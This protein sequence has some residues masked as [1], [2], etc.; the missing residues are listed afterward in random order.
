MWTA[1]LVLTLCITSATAP[2]ATGRSKQSTKPPSHARAAEIPTLE[3]LQRGVGIGDPTDNFEPVIRMKN[4][5]IKEESREQLEQYRIHHIPESN[6]HLDSN[7]E[8]IR[9]QMAYRRLVQALIV[10]DEKAK[11]KYQKDAAKFMRETG[12]SLKHA[13]NEARKEKNNKGHRHKR[14]L[15]DMTNRYWDKCI[16][17]YEYGEG[18]TGYRYV[19]GPMQT[20]EYYTGF[21]FVKWN[22][23]VQSLYGLTHNNRLRYIYENGCWSFVG[24]L[25]GS[26]QSI[27]CCG[28][29]TCMHEIGHALGFV[30]EQQSPL[31][32]DYLRVEW[33]GINPSYKGQYNR[34]NRE[35]KVLFGYYDPT[36][37]MHYGNG[38]FGVN[39]KPTMYTLDP[40]RDFL[41]GRD[42]TRY[43]YFFKEAMETHKCFDL[44]CNESLTC[45][46]GGYPSVVKGECLCV[47][48]YGLDPKTRCSSTEKTDTSLENI[49]WPAG[50]FTTL[51]TVDGCPEGFKLGWQYH[52]PPNYIWGPSLYNA[53]PY[54]YWWHLEHEFCS[55]IDE[56]ND[57][58]D[59]PAG[60]YCIYRKGGSCPTGFE[61]G[62]IQMDD[63]PTSRVNTTEGE[64]PDGVYGNN[65][66]WE[67]C[68]RRDGF[69]KTPIKLPTKHPF[70]LFMKSSC[71]VVEG[72]QANMEYFNWRSD[73][74]DGNNKFGGSLPYYFKFTESQFNLYFCYYSKVFKDCGGIYKLNSSHATNPLNIQ[75][76][77]YPN[78]Y[79]ENVD[80]SYTILAPENTTIQL[81]FNDFEIKCKRDTV[82]VA[83]SMPGHFGRKYCGSG[84][85][86]TVLSSKNYMRLTLLSKTGGGSSKGFSA[87]VRV[88]YDKCFT[89]N[90]KDRS[91]SGDMSYTQN[92]EPC[93]PWNEVQNCRFH[94]FAPETFDDD[95]SE[96]FCRNTVLG[97][98][99]WC[100][101]NA[102]TCER[103]YCDA[104]SKR[105]CYDLFNDCAALIA[106]NSSFCSINLD[107]Q[108]LR[109]CR[110][111]CGGC[112][113]VDTDKT[114][115][116]P[117]IVDN[118]VPSPAKNSSSVGD[119]VKYVCPTPG[120]NDVRTRTCTSSGTWT[121]LGF[122][123]GACPEG[124]GMVNGRCYKW[125]DTFLTHD[126][127][128]TF[129]EGL[130]AGLAVITSQK[131]HDYVYRIVRFDVEAMEG[132]WIALKRN[133]NTGQYEWDDGKTITFS[134][135]KSGE[136]DCNSDCGIYDKGGWF[137][138]VCDYRKTFVCMHTPS[139]RTTCADQSSHC[140]AFI[141]ATPDLCVL[142]T[143]FAYANCPY[144]CGLCKTEQTTS[145]STSNSTSTS[146][147]CSDPGVP[148]NTQ[149]LSS[150]GDITVGQIYKYQCNNGTALSSGD[151]IRACLITGQLTGSAPS[152]DPD[153]TVE[154]PV[155]NISIRRR[156]EHGSSGYVYTTTNQ[157]FKITKSGKLTKWRFYSSH[158]GSI[159]L[160]VWRFASGVTSSGH[161]IGEN[162]VNRT[163]DD[164]V[165]TIEIPEAQQI[166]V[167]DGD[168]IAVHYPGSSAAGIPFTRCSLD[169]EPSKNN[170]L[171]GPEIEPSSLVEGKNY[172][173]SADGYDCKTWSLNAF[174][175]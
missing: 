119:Q 30:H 61:S 22:E 9:G 32:D 77:N 25:R 8:V 152:C 110:R 129:C 127:A 141:R 174:I 45:E 134:G 99:P 148:A 147:L 137:S 71:Q 48:P 81:D 105:N 145:K 167:Q 95:L 170:Q 51:N 49:P 12:L 173:F 101:T 2:S 52:V 29:S 34:V 93:L 138:T 35:S 1:T 86:K 171:K 24:N 20:F 114:C 43:Y 5:K 65:T 164:R 107:G 175:K 153:S 76:L 91:Y 50:S 92:F 113:T 102:E 15:T 4:G 13:E 135:W 132:V 122:V 162:T 59:W 82:E 68:C 131:Q 112:K 11:T 88:I 160:Q 54:W 75:S 6:G 84:F 74:A 57:G 165:R 100:Y 58:E 78:P 73:T 55:R 44:F 36:S 144:S 97:T 133:T 3:D 103:D 125:F 154:Q 67:F 41:L 168:V 163:G 94:R 10:N 26:G 19:Q 17:P 104:C 106:D 28:G 116:A 139:E 123:C 56:Q 16:I 142:Q 130:G 140:E 79:G 33:D 157:D 150:A 63:A 151:L 172:T 83:F 121:E 27:S 118:I 90:D 143:D 146:T 47:C 60:S 166:S 98:G 37:V 158:N 128:K 21:R 96:N 149:L 40:D 66:R 31:R 72:M 14:F 70:I 23:S 115:P 136:P 156:D 46:H 124:W 39:R 111:S 18:F 155:N 109:G 159:S 126:D 161:F 69:T 80:C 53:K 117:G 7:L 108:A 85:D 42:T 169:W 87:N 62:Y 38:D 120:S 64:L 89:K